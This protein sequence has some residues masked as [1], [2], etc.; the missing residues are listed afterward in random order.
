MDGYAFRAMAIRLGAW[1]VYR[2]IL[3]LREESRRTG[4]QRRTQA[5]IED[6]LKDLPQ[7]AGEKHRKLTLVSLRNSPEWLTRCKV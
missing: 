5:I 2:Q 3:G 4:R 1:A 6:F 7:R